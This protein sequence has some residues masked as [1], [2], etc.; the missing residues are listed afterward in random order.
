MT[1]VAGVVL[2]LV[3]DAGAA[4]Y[5]GIALVL[6]ALAW[7]SLILVFSLLREPVADGED[8]D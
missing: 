2:G 6:A 4:L 1:A 7:G 8:Q 3:F 5:T